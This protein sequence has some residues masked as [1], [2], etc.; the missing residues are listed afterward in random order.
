MLDDGSDVM[1]PLLSLLL[2]RSPAIGV[3]GM[4]SHEVEKR[5]E[6][7]DGCH[8]ACEVCSC[9]WYFLCVVDDAVVALFL[10]PVVL[11]LCSDS[12]RFLSAY[13]AISLRKWLVA[14]FSSAVVCGAAYRTIATQNVATIVT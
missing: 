9:S 13:N 3:V 11:L 8:L 4:G 7:D 5:K 2:A 6:L 1:R 14:G 10:Y 12:P